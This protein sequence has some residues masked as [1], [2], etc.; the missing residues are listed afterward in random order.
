M[1]VSVAS[2]DQVHALGRNGF[3]D[4]VDLA[5]KLRAEGPDD[6][7]VVA[8]LV[9]QIG[10]TMLSRTSD[11]AERFWNDLWSVVAALSYAA[12]SEVEEDGIR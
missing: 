10:A 12:V 8:K 11:E 3:G 5:R 1:N 4:V 2:A 6:A 9:A 7:L